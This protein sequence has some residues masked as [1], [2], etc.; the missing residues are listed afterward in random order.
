MYERV[1]SKG[2]ML[3]N[4]IRFFT[5]AS[6]TFA[7]TNGVSDPF[8]Y[9]FTFTCLFLDE[10]GIEE[11]LHAEMREFFLGYRVSEFELLRIGTNEF[12]CLML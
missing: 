5:F 4:T 12:K 3:S 1:R 7:T 8:G 6:S 2:A 10:D 9:A 11:K